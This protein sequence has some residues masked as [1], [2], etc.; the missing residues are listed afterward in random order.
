MA[1][2]PYL[3]M[4]EFHAERERSLGYGKFERMFI[5]D[6]AEGMVNNFL[7]GRT[8]LEC[9]TLTKKAFTSTLDDSKL[10]LTAEE[11]LAY[12][13]AIEMLDVFVLEHG[14]DPAQL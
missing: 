9:L 14:L 11:R 10:D 6:S 3:L 7:H 8:P 13:D 2:I 12:K 1:S 5:F 4:Q